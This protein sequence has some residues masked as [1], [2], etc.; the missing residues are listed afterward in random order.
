MMEPR[1]STTVPNVSK[2]SALGMTVAADANLG[3]LTTATPAVKYFNACL[4]CIVA[5]IIYNAGNP[6]EETHAKNCAAGFWVRGDE[7]N[8]KRAVADLQ[9]S[10]D[11]TDGG[12]K[13]HPESSCSEV[14]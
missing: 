10:K 12:W 1:Q 4:R 7:C 3:R 9:K 6:R 14:A 11:S 8:R 13:T 2:T 5:G